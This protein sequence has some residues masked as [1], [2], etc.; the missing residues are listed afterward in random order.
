MALVNNHNGL[1][2]FSFSKC[3]MK[4]VA[5]LF[6]ISIHFPAYSDI[7]LEHKVK[8]AY[9]YKLLK[10][11]EWKNSPQI[12]DSATPINICVLGTGSIME[13]IR[14][15]ESKQANGRTIHILKGNPSGEKLKCHVI[16]IT[17]GEKHNLEK[18][19][20]ENYS[21][22]RL[23]ISDMEGFAESGGMIE[24]A[25][26]KGKVKLVVNKASIDNSSIRVSSKL[27]DVAVLIKKGDSI[28]ARTQ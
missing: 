7:S 14:L 17:R 18:V 12:P 3:V 5:A 19:L 9:I 20:L 27:L 28:N 25:T 23:T 22:N 2:I 4:L 26:I 8:A 24:L 6:T 13:A 1:Q 21:N 15:L 10:F 16:F 11:V